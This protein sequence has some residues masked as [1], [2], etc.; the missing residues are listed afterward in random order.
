MSAGPFTPSTK[1]SVQ[2][3]MSVQ[4]S[5]RNTFL[6]AP[7][8][9]EGIRRMGTA[10]PIWEKRETT[11]GRKSLKGFKRTNIS[12]PQGGQMGIQKQDTLQGMPFYVLICAKIH[13][14]FRN[15]YK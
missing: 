6:T 15:Y 8:Q 13:N 3:A 7:S 14:I 9:K 2:R 10:A 5:Q 4:F 11:N 1:L 12:Y